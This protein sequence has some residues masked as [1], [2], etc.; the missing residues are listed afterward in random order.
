MAQKTIVELIDD[1]DGSEA[2]QSLW[3][4]LDG[5]DCEIDLSDQNAAEL[6]SSRTKFAEKGRRTGGRKRPVTEAR[7]THLSSEQVRAWALAEGLE[8]IPRGRVQ[9]S[10]IDANLSAN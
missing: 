7:T 6:R 5:V 9:A 2:S 4:S 8:V 10:I 3:F 1:L